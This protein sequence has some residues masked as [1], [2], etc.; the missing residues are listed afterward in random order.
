MQHYKNLI[1][2]RWVESESRFEKVSP[3]DGALVG[4]VHEANSAMVD[5]AVQCGQAAARGAWGT[6]P[7]RQRVAVMR[8]L[9]DRLK[10][11]VDDLIAAE[12]ADTGRSLWQAK[13][14]DGLRAIHVLDAYCNLALN[15]ENRAGQIDLGKD[16]KGLWYTTRRPK[17]V[18]ACITPW[19]V[20]LMMMMLMASPAL[21]MG[22]AVVAKPSEETP[23]S[24][25]LLA[26]IITQSDIPPGVF[27]LL[28]GH[29]AGSTGEFLTR[30]PDVAAIVFTGESRT[31]AAIMRSASAGISDLSFELGGKNAA[32]I[33]SDADMDRTAE[34]MTRA[35]YFNC[36]QIC[37]CTE[38]AY[39][40]R[41][42]YEE[43]VSRMKKEAEKIVIG[44]QDHEGFNIGP[45][46]SANHREKV[47][48][49]LRTIPEDG[50]ELITGGDI[51][52]FGD[53]RDRGCFIRPAVAVGLSESSRLNKQ[54]VFGP[55]LH[56]RAFDDEEEVIELANDSPYGLA[57][58]I[59]TNDLS[60]AHRVAP[61]I[62]VGHAWIN[63]WQVRDLFSPLT[64]VGQSGIGEQFGRSSLE[65]CS[66]S[67]TITLRIFEE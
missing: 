24:A 58:S 49:M 53:A 15:L 7:M 9:S 4:I 59:W 41:S 52:T 67:Q 43:F 17:G 18:I 21:V 46:I 63:S 30:H 26:E 56:I 14:Y 13:T 42:R 29:G 36:G 51:P 47:M 65:F 12:M 44:R 2:G 11:R 8:N 50:G 22:N 38:R 54:E 27:S 60:R 48:S 32:L 1:A 62:R 34:G 5:E 39:V 19:N 40:H 37:F 23:S 33:F 35:A 16:F 57:T 45:L 61:R 3:Y 25:A 66:Y 20:P 64:G 28:H 55:V 31:G 10:D 6:M